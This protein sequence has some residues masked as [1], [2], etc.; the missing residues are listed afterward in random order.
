[1]LSLKRKF[2]LWRNGEIRWQRQ[3]LL[4]EESKCKCSSCSKSEV[5]ATLSWMQLN[6]DTDAGHHLLFKA[7]KLWVLVTRLEHSGSWLWQSLCCCLGLG[8]TDPALNSSPL[9]VAC[10]NATPTHDL[11]GTKWVVFQEVPFF[12]CN[13]H[14]IPLN[15]ASPLHFFGVII[16]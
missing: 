13:I 15:E 4:L 11:F 6:T 7:Q 9:T 10:F 3:E 16:E 12:I 1:M 8:L 2:C 14:S 5:W